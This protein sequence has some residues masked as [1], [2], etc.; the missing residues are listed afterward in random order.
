MN[1]VL[2]LTEPD[3]DYICRGPVQGFKILLHTPGEIPRVSKQYFRVPLRQEVVVSVKPNMITTSSG[4]ADYAPE[5]RQCYFNDERQLKFFKVYTQS[6]CELECLA[7]FTLAKC[8]C[9]K[10]S[11]PRDNQ[12]RICTQREVPCYD[13]AEDSLMANELKQSLH[14]GSGENKIGI[15]DCYCLPSCTSINYDAEISQADYN[16]IKV[17]NAYGSDLNE[18][19]D[20]ILARLT[21]FFKE[22]QFITSKRSELYGLTDF[23]ANCGGLLGLFMGVSIL[24]LIEILYYITL[25]L[26]CNLNYRRKKRN[27]IR[28]ASIIDGKSEPLPGIKIDYSNGAEGCK[29]D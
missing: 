17:F 12:T 3:L 25:R 23:M 1:I 18:Y 2:K 20:M 7:N 24:S 14:S 22:A 19:P 10:F 27:K 21:I 15:T 29:N 5:R 13:E 11:M 26:A 16:Y 4:L 6:N 28:R 8:D 9:V